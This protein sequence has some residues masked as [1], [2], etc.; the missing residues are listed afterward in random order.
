MTHYQLWVCLHV[1]SVIVWV[2]AGTTLV[3]ATL[4]AQR[5]ADQPLGA[6]T[7]FAGWL[8]PRVF[9]PSSLAALGFG[10][11]AARSGHLG[12]AALDP[13]GHRRVRGLVSAQRCCAICRCCGGLAEAA[14]RR[15]ERLSCCARS[16]SL[17]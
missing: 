5:A 16:P 17:T 1:A 14:P 6:V 2:G 7:G 8:G 13:P 11:V 15:A 4:Y 3:L 10:I 12:V 9:A